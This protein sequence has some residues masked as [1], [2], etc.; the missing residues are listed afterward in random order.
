MIID[1]IRKSSLPTYPARPRRG[2]HLTD[3]VVVKQKGG[4]Y[5]AK[6]DGDHIVG[7]MVT[8]DVY[9]RHGEPYRNKLASEQVKKLLPLWKWLAAQN[10]IEYHPNGSGK[11]QVDRLCTEENAWVS[12][13]FLCKHKQWKNRVAPIDFPMRPFTHTD[14]RRMI[15]Y[16]P[17][18]RHDDSDDACRVFGGARPGRA[19]RS[20]GMKTH[21]YAS[22]RMVDDHTILLP[23]VIHHATASGAMVMA[24]YKILRKLA[25]GY[26]KRDNETTP[27]YEGVVFVSDSG[28]YPL[29][30]ADPSRKAAGWIK[31]RFSV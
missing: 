31:H 5:T 9:N 24:F 13:E 19:M 14:M 6:V 10:P 25:E 18:A 26:M 17:L 28:R 4:V 16:Y 11:A 22:L 15:P 23:C 21:R 29:Q 3:D 27:F 7:N 2:E 12:A 8:G 20:Q 1:S 30:L